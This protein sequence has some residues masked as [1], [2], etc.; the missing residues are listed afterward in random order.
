MSS[1]N[2]KFYSAFAAIATLAIAL[3][4]YG[5][6]ALIGTRDLVVRLYDEPLISVS[7]ARAA[8][9]TLNEASGLMAQGLML[10]PGQMPG[11]VAALRKFQSAINDDLEIVPWSSMRPSGP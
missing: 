5:G 4:V 9:A 8:G 1:L 11:A 3:A 2:R 10:G 7:Y 6:H